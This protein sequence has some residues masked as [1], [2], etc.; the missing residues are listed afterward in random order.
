MRRTLSV[1]CTIAPFVAAAIAAFGGR[2]DLRMLWMA[3][4]VTLVAQV[5]HALTARLRGT[6]SAALSLM[7]G[8]IAAS[9][10]ALMAGARAPFGIIAVALV[11]A[12]FATAG[13]WLRVP[14]TTDSGGR[15]SAQRI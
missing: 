5:V 15:G 2:H 14:R 7:L 13:V 9:A 11:L 10:I 6:F 12:V 3:I 8:T 4:V 1:L